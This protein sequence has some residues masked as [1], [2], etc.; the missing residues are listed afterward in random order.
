MFGYLLCLVNAVQRSAFG[1]WCSGLLVLG[2]LFGAVCCVQSMGLFSEQVS[3][4]CSR[5]PSKL[6]G[7]NGLQIS[8]LENPATPNGT[9]T[10]S[11]VVT[12]SLLFG[13]CASS[14]NC[15]STRSFSLKGVGRYWN[16][17]DSASNR[18]PACPFIG[19]TSTTHFQCSPRICRRLLDTF[20]P[21]LQV[22][23]SA[24]CESRFV[25]SASTNF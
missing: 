10:P 12:N 17:A 13:E 16:W 22:N 21:I 23:F 11:T 15:A 18:L 6:Q 2:V 3:A 19:P 7:R 20:V 9:T 24:G 14:W 5:G 1:V 8:G 4:G 25:T